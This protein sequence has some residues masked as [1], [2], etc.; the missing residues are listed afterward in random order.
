MT[1]PAD[2]QRGLQAYAQAQALHRERKLAEAVTLYNRALALMPDHPHVLVSFAELAEEVKDWGAVEKLYRRLGTLR[3][4]IDYQGHLGVA[5]FRLR[6]WAEALPFLETHMA[7]HPGDADVLHAISNCLC[8]LG[9]WE[10]GLARARTAMQLKPNDE[11]TDAVLNAL[12]HLGRDAELEP[13]L[14]AALQKFPDSRAIRSMYGLHHLKAGHYDAGFRYFSDF[15]WRSNL[16]VPDNA[17]IP[18]EAW[19]GQPFDGTLLVVAEQGLGDEIM[20]SSMLEELV[21]MGQRAIVECDPR[22]IPLFARSFPTL[23][24]V[25]RYQKQL[26]RAFTEGGGTGFRRVNALDMGTFFRRDATRF[27]ARTHWLQPDPQRV[28]ALRAD[29]R[30]RWP[31]RKIIGLSWKSSRL[32]EGGADKS[33]RLADFT[34]L[35]QRDDCAMINLQYGDVRADIDALRASGSGELF[36][37]ERIDASN[38]IDALA[39]QIAALDAVVSTSNTTVHIA[40]A[41]GVPCLVLLPRTRPVLW[42]WGYRGERTPWYP[43]LRLLRNES[44]DERSEL[45][46]RA[47]S[48]GAPSGATPTPIAP[49]GA[50][51]G[52]AP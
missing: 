9:Q 38:D 46:Q 20:M 51:T 15:R 35:L 21:A 5:L 44:E 41:L 2:I 31:G 8:S 1:S 39:A 47:A 18:C 34:P 37:D 33:F 13:Q 26:Q 11:I 50:P 7:R 42:Y 29:Y 32:Q 14:A 4:D 17:G 19:D 3:P 10:E 48:V 24:F 28:A 23:E 52:A 43:S 27:P 30:A 22:L 45:M 6:R 25:P 36:V 16:D 12:Y 40:G 49:E